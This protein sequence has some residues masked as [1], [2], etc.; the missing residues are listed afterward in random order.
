M[1]FKDMVLDA[2]ATEVLEE[3]LENQGRTAAADACKWETMIFSLA[4]EVS[5]DV[6][7]AC[8][9]FDEVMNRLET[10]NIHPSK[11]NAQK[12]IYEIAV[13]HELDSAGETMH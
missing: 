9:I 5:E 2:M 13:L 12:L 8:N 6:N 4:N 3:V 1:K 7:V 11:L 10:G